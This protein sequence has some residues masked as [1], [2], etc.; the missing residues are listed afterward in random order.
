MRPSSFGDW[1]LGHVAAAL[2]EVWNPLE[3]QD[4][5]TAYAKVGLLLMAVEQTTRASRWDLAQLVRHL[6]DPPLEA[7]GSHSRRSFAAGGLST[8]DKDLGRREKVRER[9]GKREAKMNEA[10]IAY[11]WSF[12]ESSLLAVRSCLLS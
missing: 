7:G 5:S 10:A 6:P 2:S 11:P 9:M 8:T 1:A 3:M 4:V 12:S